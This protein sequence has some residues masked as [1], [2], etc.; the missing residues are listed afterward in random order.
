MEDTMSAKIREEATPKSKDASEPRQHRGLSKSAKAVLEAPPRTFQEVN[1]LTSWIADAH[2]RL[3]DTLGELGK[4][5]DGERDRMLLETLSKDERAHADALREV[6]RRESGEVSGESFVQT[7]PEPLVDE[8]L[9]RIDALKARKSS[10]KILEDVVSID[11]G[12]TEF[13]EELL[14]RVPDGEIHDSVASLADLERQ[15]DK[16]HSWTLQSGK[17]A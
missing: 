17:D 8:L 12:L 2:V 16:R 5:A 7:P 3:A 11:L 14:P 10:E 4:D 1:T 13:F 6:V 9:A 15:L